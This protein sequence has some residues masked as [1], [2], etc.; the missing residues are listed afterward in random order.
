MLSRLVSARALAGARPRVP[1]PRRNC[2][3]V[4][5]P[6]APAAS[7]EKLPPDDRPFVVRHK[8]AILFTAAFGSW[9]SSSSA[10]A[11]GIAPKPREAARRDPTARLVLA[12]DL[13]ARHGQPDAA[14][15][16]W[17]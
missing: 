6:S 17:P 5:A 1:V 14:T 15:S 11:T 9:V 16:G 12:T 4:A 13:H 7:A 10:H 3:T 2:A 8:W